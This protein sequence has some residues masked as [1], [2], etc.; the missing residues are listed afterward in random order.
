MK[1]RLYLVIALVIALAMLAYA[2]PALA[3][4]G[5]FSGD[6]DFGGGLGGSFDSEGCDAGSGMNG[7]VCMPVMIGG[8]GDYSGGSDSCTGTDM[9]IIAVIVIIVLIALWFMRKKTAQ[10]PVNTGVRP[11]DDAELIPVERYIAEFDEGFS[12]ADMQTRLANLY[13]QLQDQWEEKDITP[14]RPF[15]TDELYNQSERQLNEIRRSGMTPHV[16]NIAVLSVNLRGWFQRDGMDHMIVEL[17]TR[18]TTFSTSDRTGAV[19]KGDPNREKFMTYEWDLC[20]TSGQ[21]TGDA[22]PMQTINCPNCGA[23]VSINKSAKCPY[24]ESVITLDEHDWVLYS[25]KGISQRTQ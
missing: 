8:G 11:T 25:I 4:F 10:T 1:K 9:M 20:R 2:V 18:I 23:P 5:G 3:D 17:I 19:V 24:C 12:A 16:D 21:K 7:G 15:L 14:L 6:S 22:A 13:V